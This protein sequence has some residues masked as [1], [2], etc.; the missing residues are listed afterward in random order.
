M[1]IRGSRMGDKPYIYITK[2]G[3]GNLFLFLQDHGI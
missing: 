1:G 2:K 3:R